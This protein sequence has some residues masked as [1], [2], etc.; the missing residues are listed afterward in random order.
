MNLATI[1]YTRT[2]TPSRLHQQLTHTRAHDQDSEHMALRV[3]QASREEAR[4]K[5]RLIDEVSVM[6]CAV[7]WCGVR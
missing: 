3:M 2:H 7:E 5:K 4:E 1:V 6:W